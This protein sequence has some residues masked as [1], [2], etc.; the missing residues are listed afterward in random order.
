M[1]TMR[2]LSFVLV[3]AL[4]ACGKDS[5]PPAQQEEVVATSPAADE[6]RQLFNTVCSTCHGADGKGN[7]AAAVSLNPKPRDYTDKAWQASTTDDQIRNIILLGGAGVGKSAAMPAQV[8][9]K[10]KPLVVEE[11]VRLVRAFGK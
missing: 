7:G 9:L 5:Q 2:T 8:Q 1:F 10:D 4:A 6:A 11:L 3:A